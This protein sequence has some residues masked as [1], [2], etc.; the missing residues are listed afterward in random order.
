MRG[1][2][3]A[4][5]VRYIY[6][7]IHIR[8]IWWLSVLSLWCSTCRNMHPTRILHFRKWVNFQRNGDIAITRNTRIMWSDTLF[9]LVHINLAAIHPGWVPF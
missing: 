1:V 6:V 8:D 3:F 4:V 7:T 5:I 9:A 2:S